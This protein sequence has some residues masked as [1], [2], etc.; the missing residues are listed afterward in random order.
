MLVAVVEPRVNV[1]EQVPADRVQVVAENV[2]AP[3]M[4]VNVTVPVGVEA[5]GGEVSA[6]V[7]VQV[8]G[9]PIGTVA[10]EHEMVV[11]VVRSV[12]VTVVVPTGNAEWV[13]SPLYVPVIV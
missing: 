5:V 7:A 13:E 8:E 3:P 12:T 9:C 10:G 11:L 2:P 4:L 6:T 1:T